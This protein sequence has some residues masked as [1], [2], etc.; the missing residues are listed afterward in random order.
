MT[1]TVIGMYPDTEQ[2]YSAIVETEG[3][4]DEVI[5][6]ALNQCAEENEIARSELDL[7]IVAVIAGQPALLWERD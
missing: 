2:A 3:D 7:W 5:D 4:V 1:F 6:L